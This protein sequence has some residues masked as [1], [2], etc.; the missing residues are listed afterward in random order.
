[1]MTMQT[2]AVESVYRSCLRSIENEGLAALSEELAQKESGRLSVVDPQA[3][4][5]NIYRSN[6]EVAA[7]KSV[8]LCACF[9]CRT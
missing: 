3:A 1:M 2:P 6:V 9:G 8:A 7:H 5:C 4:Y